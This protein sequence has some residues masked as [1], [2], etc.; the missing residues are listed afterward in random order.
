MLEEGEVDQGEGEDELGEEEVEL[1][2]EEVELRQTLD[3]VLRLITVVAPVQLQHNSA[4][5]ININEL[6]GDDDE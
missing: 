3:H 2:V 4:N 5:N 1:V 6:Q